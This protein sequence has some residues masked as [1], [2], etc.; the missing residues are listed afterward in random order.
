[1][2]LVNEEPA[3]HVAVSWRPMIECE[4][5]RFDANQT[6]GRP[7][8]A[9]VGLARYGLRPRYSPARRWSSSGLWTARATHSNARGQ[10]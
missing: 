2:S 4:P 1:M 8:H 5:V 10:C 7:C 3:G 6:A 9:L